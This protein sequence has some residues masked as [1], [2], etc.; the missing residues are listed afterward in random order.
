MGAA[1]RPKFLEIGRV[2]RHPLPQ[3]T[4]GETLRGAGVCA[5]R[6]WAVI[7]NLGKEPPPPSW[8]LALM[9]TGT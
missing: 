3:G 8:E 1:H 9:G 4:A 5:G 6:E 7:G 2:H